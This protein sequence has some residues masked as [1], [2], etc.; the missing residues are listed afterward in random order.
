MKKTS[1]KKCLFSKPA[2][3]SNPCEHGVIQHLLDTQNKTLNIVEDYYQIEDYECKMGFSRETM[4]LNKDLITIED[5]K[6]SVIRNSV[7]IYLILDIS[8]TTPENIAT[9]C[10]HIDD[11]HDL[12]RFV[13]FCM[14]SDDSQVNK[15]KI[16][17]IRSS[18]KSDIPW[19][20]HVLIENVPYEK[21]LH[22]IISSNK[23]SNGSQFL[24]IYDIEKTSELKR[25][26]NEINTICTIEQRDFHVMQKTGC[27]NCLNGLLI[28]FN[29][30]FTAKRVS[31][32]ILD[33]IKDSKEIIIYRYGS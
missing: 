6:Q 3:D 7:K 30:Y 31:D 21:A 26:L 13:S 14:F 8:T 4:D 2:S 33:T 23:N 11:N 20:V 18:L 28:S 9:H 24:L 27:D 12:V 15:E 19:K 22:P 17:I 1:C 25:D 29:N 32:N 10:K 16:D 5:I